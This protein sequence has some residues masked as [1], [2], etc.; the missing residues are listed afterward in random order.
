[1][2]PVELDLKDWQ[3]VINILGAANA[4]W[5]IVNPLM[6]KIVRQVEMKKPD[7]MPKGDGY[8]ISFEPH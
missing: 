4:P 1:M 6:L 7:A 8:G 2:I 3:Q 5:V